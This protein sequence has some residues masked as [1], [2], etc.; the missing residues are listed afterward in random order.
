MKLF[1]KET[2][3]LSPKLSESCGFACAK[4]GKQIYEGQN[5]CPECAT[6]L[7]W[8]T[9]IVHLAKRTQYHWE[10]KNG[11]YTL[12]IRQWD[13][14]KIAELRNVF[15][16]EWR[17]DMVNTL[18]MVVTIEAETVEEAMTKSLVFIKN[19][20]MKDTVQLEK[21]KNALI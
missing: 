18:R 13:T 10:E 9:P 12:T 1:K 2:K 17:L 16:G 11:R 7:D 20:V 6:P 21:L 14:E 3:K 4:C 19:Q 5:F 15:D 8:D